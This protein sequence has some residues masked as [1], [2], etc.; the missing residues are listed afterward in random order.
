MRLL[1]LASGESIHSYK[2]VK[3]FADRGHEVVWISAT[4]V[5]FDDVGTI[6]VRVLPGQKGRRA[7]L[8]K[9]IPFTRSVISEFRPDLIH[10]HYLGFYALLAL[11]SGAKRIVATAWGSDV[12]FGRRSLVKRFVVKTILRR[13]A[14]STCDA[15]HMVKAMR[16]IAGPDTDVRIV[17]F[18]TDTERFA[19]R[20]PDPAELAKLDVY[21]DGPVVISLRSFLPVYEIETVVRAAAIIIAK[22]PDARVLLVGDGP[23]RAKLEVLAAELDLGEGLQFLGR[24]PNHLLPELLV[25]SSVYVS[26]ALSDAGIAASTQEAMACQVPVVI[27]DS[28]ENELWVE[29]GVNGFLVPVSEPD[30]MAN[31]VLRMLDSPENAN[32]MAARGR[33]TIVERA[34]FDTEMSRMEAIY[35]EVAGRVPQ[36]APT[37]AG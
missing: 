34:G 17:Q 20:E 9:A 8:W 29:D 21:V 30:A 10:V 32:R 24:I 35:S 18:G 6:D 27:T 31:A 7:S 12:V 1:F 37:S 16:E 33:E 13:A 2:W 25:A 5:E 19:P 22:R 15:H 23:E 14:V 11:F 26:S 36:G 4:P 28:G 3:C